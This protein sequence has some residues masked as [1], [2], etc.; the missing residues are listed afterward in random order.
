MIKLLSTDFDGT[1]VD[2]FGIPPVSPDLFELFGQLQKEEVRWA[3]NT[4]RD[5]CHIVTGLSEFNFPIQPDFVLTSERDVFRRTPDGQ[6]WEPYGDW[7]ERCARAHEEMFLKARPLLKKILTFIQRETRA[8]AIQHGE[9]PDGLIAE[10][11]VEM[12]RIVA[13]IESVREEMPLFSYQRNTQYLRFCHAEYSKGAALGELGRLLGVSSDQIFA[14]G[15]HHNDIPMLD[16]KSARWIACPANSAE[17]V[18]ET[19]RNAGGYIAKGS[20][21]HG[22]VEALRHFL[23]G[24]TA[25]GHGLKDRAL[26]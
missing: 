9:Q 10:D 26:A 19:V 24:G 5:L 7:N 4:G 15:D 23:N 17:A 16:G 1:L 25:K 6:D 3:I 18:K 20:C 14:T 21:S 12:D 13:F 11:E 2:H 22:V 8:Q